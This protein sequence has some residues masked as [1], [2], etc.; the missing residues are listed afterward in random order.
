M[1]QQNIDILMQRALEGR[2]RAALD[3]VAA[4][5]ARLTGCP[6]ALVSIVEEQRQWF[7][8]MAGI[9]A[10]ETPIEQSFCRW[11]VAQDSMLVVP[12]ASADARFAEIPT[13]A[14][15][16]PNGEPPIRFYAGEPLRVSVE[17]GQ[18]PVPI[19][20]LCV[21]SG[22]PREL[23]DHCREL[24][25]G[26]GRA[27]SEL[28][29]ARVNTVTAEDM[30]RAL[31]ETLAARD[32]FQRQLQQAERMTRVGSWRLALPSQQ[33]EWSDQIFVI[34]ELPSGSVKALEDALG[35]Y[36][37]PDRTIL[38]RAL[39]N[40]IQTGA[41][42]DLTLDF[43]T[44]RGNPR[45]VRVMGDVERENATLV[46][47]IGAMQDVTERYEVERRL[48][49]RADT[50]ELTRIATRRRFNEYC[51]A[52][53]MD[54]AGDQ[55][56]LALALIDLDHFKQVNDRFGHNCGDRVLLRAATALT[57]DWLANCF[58]A[59][60]GGDE[61]VL[62]ITD[63]ALIS[64]LPGTVRRLLD[65]LVLPIPGSG[66]LHSTAT[67]GVC[68]HRAGAINRS[69]LMSLADEA[70]YAAKDRSRGTAAINIAGDGEDAPMV[71]E[72]MIMVDPSSRQPGDPPL[73]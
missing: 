2:P 70:L 49:K 53:L 37:E 16:G 42:F 20:A 46:A 69:D 58:P 5:A 72:A 12:D 28:I 61:L 60:L 3:A 4:A 54:S 39:G 52:L 67:I 71:T 57:S 31:H 45:K 9:V 48:R 62:L 33:A 26:L 63:P 6:S 29:Q 32:R 25:E 56:P 68:L 14:G 43:V 59:R 30:A 65:E 64:D 27:A 22:A 8:A 47:V 15:P 36:P 21:V 13:V 24:L 55:P 23:D 17:P 10:T 38:E 73:R 1:I 35:Y 66:G 41:P 44:A 50:D 40:T 19:G 7:P 51:D 18:K 34:H 11:A